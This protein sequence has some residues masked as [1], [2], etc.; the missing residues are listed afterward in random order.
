MVIEPQF[1]EVN[2][3]SEGLAMVDK[4]GKLGYVDKIGKVVIEPQFDDAR[5]FCE[6]LAMVAIES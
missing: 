3:F 1:D 2:V 5:N 4:D 6:S